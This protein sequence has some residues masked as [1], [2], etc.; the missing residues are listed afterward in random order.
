MLSGGSARG[1]AHLGVLRV[2]EREG[3]RPDLVVGTSAGAIAGALWAAGMCAAD[4]EELARRVDRA[5]VFDI[6][7]WRSLFA[8]LGLGLARGERLE[9]L[10]RA[11]LPASIGELPTRFA[12]VATDL[13]RGGMVVLDRGDL[14]RA[15]RASAAIPGLVEPVR[16]G[17][18]LLGD[19]QIVSPL[20]V[21]AARRLGARRVVAVDVVYPP[22]HAVLSNPLSVVFQT[23]V[24]A[25]YGHLERE[26][27][28]ADLVIA[29]AI[30]PVA[31]RLGLGQGAHLVHNGVEAAERALPQ[32][33]EL[34][35]ARE[36]ALRRR[37]AEGGEASRELAPVF[38]CSPS[39]AS[40]PLR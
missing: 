28:A 13:N 2:L 24:I 9:R 25:S 8:G 23:L 21:E 18:R 38:L 19:G 22:E 36:P 16:I 14:A 34:F 40:A 33:R 17:E 5:T 39:A 35:G 29:P 20:P 4:I 11:H 3:W 6:A 27:E 12:A 1:F 7:P 31:W 32:L 26:R 15:L 30:P 10:L 37:A